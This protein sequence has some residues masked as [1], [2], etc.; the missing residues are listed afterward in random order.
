MTTVAMGPLVLHT[1]NV[2]WQPSKA[3]TFSQ[4]EA[5]GKAYPA[6]VTGPG[7]LEI[8][9]E[10]FMSLDGEGM[11]HCP[12]PATVPADY[13]RLAHGARLGVYV[14]SDGHW[15]VRQLRLLRFSGSERWGNPTKTTLEELN[16]LLGSS[17]REL[18]SSLGA[19]D[20][21]P[22]SVVLGARGDDLAMR[23]LSDKGPE[24]PLSAYV[25]TRVLPIYQA[26]N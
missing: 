21:G 4:G 22:K 19:I 9:I 23:W 5:H 8:D 2:G 14:D 1:N 11:V 17:V 7:G 16:G 13:T 3:S 20:V 15:T 25:L 18:M 10:M 12:D 26:L 6:T 24:L